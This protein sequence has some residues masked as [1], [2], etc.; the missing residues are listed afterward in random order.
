MPPPVLPAV[1]AGNVRLTVYDALGK[2]V[3]LLVNENLQ[4]GIY[5][6]DLDASNIPSGVY[7]YRIEAKGY[8]ETKKM[9]VVK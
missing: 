3:M 8:I 5:E 6:T 4:A 7:F 9:I 2:E 1:T